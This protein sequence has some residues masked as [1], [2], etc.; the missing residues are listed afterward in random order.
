MKEMP[1]E[2]LREDNAGTTPF[3]N[4]FSIGVPSVHVIQ[5][6]IEV[7]PEM[8]N[9]MSMLLQAFCRDHVDYAEMI[10]LLD[11]ETEM[12]LEEKMEEKMTEVKEQNKWLQKRRKKKKKTWKQHV[13]HMIQQKQVVLSLQQHKAFEA[14]LICESAATNIQRQMRGSIS[15][16]KHRK[17]H[18]IA[19]SATLIQSLRRGSTIRTKLIVPGKTRLVHGLKHACVETRRQLGRTSW[20]KSTIRSVDWSEE[21]EVLETAVKKFDSSLR[22]HYNNLHCW[23]HGTIKIKKPQRVVCALLKRL[24]VSSNALVRLEDRHHHLFFSFNT[25]QQQEEEKEKKRTS[26]ILLTP[27]PNKK[28]NNSSVVVGRTS[29]TKIIQVPDIPEWPVYEN[30]DDIRNHWAF[31]R[32]EEEDREILQT[33]ENDLMSLNGEEWEEYADIENDLWDAI[34]VDELEREIEEKEMK[35]REHVV[36]FVA[37]PIGILLKNVDNSNVLVVSG[38]EIEVD[39]TVKQ[40]ILVGDE[41]VGFQ[42]ELNAIYF[43]LYEKHE[44]KMQRLA[45]C[46]WPLHL[47]LRRPKVVVEEDGE[48]GKENEKEVNGEDDKDEAVEV[49]AKQ[50]MQD[51]QV[52]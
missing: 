15:R 47:I 19:A 24:S 35:T 18:A 34:D 40:K 33:I 48:E 22:S 17:I 9:E 31:H 30:T 44:E 12:E 50:E 6:L 5:T 51:V 8:K 38:F 46:T 36:T 7:V 14:E 10:E 4:L 42:I 28:K 2:T 26:A 1:H 21:R 49:D 45:E 3:D 16:T 23:M 20:M 43:G 13:Q 52:K 32:L 41:L 39:D 29:S 25:K 11:T 37:P 27:L